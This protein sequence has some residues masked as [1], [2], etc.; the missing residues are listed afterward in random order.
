MNVAF[1]KFPIMSPYSCL[2]FT[3][4]YGIHHKYNV[5][6]HIYIYLAIQSFFT[7]FHVGFYLLFGLLLSAVSMLVKKR[8]AAFAVAYVALLLLLADSRLGNA[9]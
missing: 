5:Y 9:R 8:A 3:F 7:F 4:Y 1:F 6:I 2:P